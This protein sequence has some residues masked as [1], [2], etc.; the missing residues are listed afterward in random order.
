MLK[1]RHDFRDPLSE[2]LNFSSCLRC[3]STCIHLSCRV[4]R[5]NML[6]WMETKRG[7][8]AFVL[9]PGFQIHFVK[10][11]LV[12]LWDTM[13]S[14]GCGHVT[15]HFWFMMFHEIYKAGAGSRTVT[16]NTL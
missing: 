1:M 3:N 12:I 8:S 7:S 15:D 6:R 16:L 13:G 2:D 5:G 10:S 9:R 4:H 14:C 11:L